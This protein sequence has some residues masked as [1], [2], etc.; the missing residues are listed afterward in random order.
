MMGTPVYEVEELDNFS[1]LNYEDPVLPLEPPRRHACTQALQL[2][3]N[4]D[5]L[6]GRADNGA[7]S[8]PIKK[9]AWRLHR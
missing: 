8:R 3:T 9:C 2:S 7:S 1:A 6:V 5:T 4:G